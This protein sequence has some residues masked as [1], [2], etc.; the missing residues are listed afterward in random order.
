MKIKHAKHRRI[1]NVLILAMHAGFLAY[2]PEPRN[3]IQNHKRKN[4]NQREKKKALELCQEHD[5]QKEKYKK[6]G[7]KTKPVYVK[8]KE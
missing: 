6:H 1:E 2:R 5:E 3:T 8:L 4:R 7:L